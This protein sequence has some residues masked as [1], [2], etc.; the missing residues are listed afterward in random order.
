MSS[1]TSVT[2]SFFHC[3]PLKLYFFDEISASRA[4]VEI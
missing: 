2:L 3:V 1:S 4:V